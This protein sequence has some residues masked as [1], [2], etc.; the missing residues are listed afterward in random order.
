MM[1][2]ATVFGLL[3]QIFFFLVAWR[4]KKLILGVRIELSHVE[5]L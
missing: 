1:P 4:E 3:G 2:L 5:K